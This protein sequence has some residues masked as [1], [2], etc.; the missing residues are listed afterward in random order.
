MQVSRPLASRRTVAPQTYHRS[1]R[2]FNSL[3]KPAFLSQIL[4][5]YYSYLLTFPHSRRHTSTISFM[6]LL[7]KD[8]AS[9]WERLLKVSTISLSHTC[10]EVSSPTDTTTLFRNTVSTGFSYKLDGRMEDPLEGQRMHWQER[11]WPSSYNWKNTFTCLNSCTLNL[12]WSLEGL[13]TAWAKA[14][15]LLKSIANR[16]RYDFLGFYCQGINNRMSGEH[17]HIL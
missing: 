2:C 10:S 3:P 8:M 6:V 12:L 17:R 9:L 16:F 4:A 1:V 13:Y 15:W 11:R 7:L 14:S 5:W